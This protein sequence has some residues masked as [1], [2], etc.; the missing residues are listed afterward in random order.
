MN[1]IVSGSRDFKN[2]G[3]FRSAMAI[4]GFWQRKIECMILGDATGV[5]SLAENYAKFYNIPYKKFEADW[6]TNGRAA[7]PIRNSAMVDY[8]KKLGNCH[9]LALWEFFC[10]S[11]QKW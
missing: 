7:G 9:L 10:F 6:N 5:D 11:P 2:Y 3:E 4:T 1:L 8:G